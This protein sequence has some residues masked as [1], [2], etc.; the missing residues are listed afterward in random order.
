MTQQ[1]G[2]LESRGPIETTMKDRHKSLDGLVHR[3]GEMLR[4]FSARSGRGLLL[5][6]L[7]CLLRSQR[8]ALLALLLA[9]LLTSPLLMIIATL[10]HTYPR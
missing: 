9:N 8:R 6:P 1:R 4:A 7:G 3:G 10:R 5:L 2:K